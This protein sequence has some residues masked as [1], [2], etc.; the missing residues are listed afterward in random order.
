MRKDVMGMRLQQNAQRG[1]R[2]QSPLKL[3]TA[4]IYS[5]GIAAAVHSIAN[6]TSS[7]AMPIR[8]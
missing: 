7:R 2:E 4:L 1:V 6:R 8:G 5:R 3:E